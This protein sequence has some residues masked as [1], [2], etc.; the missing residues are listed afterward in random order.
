MRPGETTSKLRSGPAPYLAPVPVAKQ[1][2]DTALD[3]G[4]DPTS[5]GR[6]CHLT[7]GRTQSQRDRRSTSLSCGADVGLVVRA[8]HPTELA[9]LL[10]YIFKASLVACANA[11]VVSILSGARLSF[12]A[13]R[14]LARQ[15]NALGHLQSEVLVV[16][17]SWAFRQAYP[18][19]PP[20]EVAAP[21]RNLW[22]PPTDLRDDEY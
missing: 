7:E 2:L 19:A 12:P 5:P 6:G 21:I 9:G 18:R 1:G 11:S 13:C 8:A 22:A 17:P 4:P 16:I 3:R 10:A 14:S 20:I 15:L